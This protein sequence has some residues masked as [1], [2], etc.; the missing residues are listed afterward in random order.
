MK[1]KVLQQFN[2]W[3]LDKFLAE[4]MPETSRSQI[5]KQIKA[6]LVF[7][8]DKKPTVHEFLKTG[9]IVVIQQEKIKKAAKKVKKI[10]TKDFSKEL[11]KKIGIIDQTD[12]YL[13]INKPANLLVHPTEAKEKYTLVSWLIK[14]FPE[15]K[16]I[17]EDPARPAIVHRLD[18]ETSGLMVIPKTQKMFEHLKKQF[19]KRLIEK[20]YFALVYG[21]LEAKENTISFRIGRSSQTGKMAAHPASSELGKS[22]L[23]GYEVIKEYKKFSFLKIKPKTGRTHQIRVHLFALE[24]PV[25]GD[26]LYYSKKYK[27]IDI[28]RMFLQAYFLSF[29]DLEGN[30]KKY[31]IELEDE[32]K[33]FISSKII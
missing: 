3:R 4:K 12:D 17:G 31:E 19:Q 5:K 10:F 20:K 22:A 21:H 11:F 7:V 26:K 30:K 6:G 32:L 24:H 25:V 2:D 16:K 14:K 8:N 27:P 13:I 29:K 23:T 9:D 28:D 1:Y 18:K 33:N 15:L